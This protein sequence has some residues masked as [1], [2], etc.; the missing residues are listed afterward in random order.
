M[1]LSR[2]RIGHAARIEARTHI[3]L[4]HMP[5]LGVNI[6]HVATVRQVRYR[7]VTS[8]QGGF[9]GEPDPLRAAH[10][11]ELGGAETITVYLR[12]R[13]AARQRPRRPSTQG[14]NRDATEPGD[15]RDR[16]DDQDRRES[17]SADVHAGSRGAPGSDDRG[18][19]GCRRTGGAAEGL[20]LAPA[21]CGNHRVGVHQCSVGPSTNSITSARR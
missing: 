6:D 20:R 1:R 8:G 16:R 4:R 18:R 10:E 9:M 15:G 11:A 14:N 19:S 3:S 12:E 2:C 21:R 5:L 13:P 17:A 7:G